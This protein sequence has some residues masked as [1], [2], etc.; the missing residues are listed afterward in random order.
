MIS[1]PML[2]VQQP[3][4]AS[5]T[6]Q[7][8]LPINNVL[9]LDSFNPQSLVSERSQ[10]NLQNLNV[11]IVYQVAMRKPLTQTNAGVELTEILNLLKQESKQGIQIL[12]TFPNE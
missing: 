12:L 4:A 5:V 7:Q 8:N 2:P 6:I 1:K 3:Q 11:P 9:P 10:C